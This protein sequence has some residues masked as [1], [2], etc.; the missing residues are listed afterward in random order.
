MLGSWE[1][2]IETD[3]D[4]QRRMVDGQLDGNAI[5][6]QACRKNITAFKRDTQRNPRKG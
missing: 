4:R 5:G 2:N 1:G 3:R 6:W